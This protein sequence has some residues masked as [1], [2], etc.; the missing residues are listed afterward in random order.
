[1]I[2][3]DAEAV[4]RFE[5]NSEQDTFEMEHWSLEQSKLG[6]ASRKPLQGMVVAITGGAGA[7]G[8]ATARAFAQRGAELA[9]LDADEEAAA[10]VVKYVKGA[11]FRCDVTKP[12][13]VET[14]FA[15]IARLFGGLDVLVSNAGAA[16][17]GAIG[18]VPEVIL[19]ESFELNFFGHQR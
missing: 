4:G 6:K 16:W 1:E 12:E 15:D 7:I 17:T 2:V 8:A 11:H 13:E 9:V 5:S 19:R 3:R 14:V 10:R 18:E